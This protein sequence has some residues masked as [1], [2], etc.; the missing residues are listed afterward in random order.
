VLNVCLGKVRAAAEINISPVLSIHPSLMA[1]KW[2]H[3][4]FKNWRMRWQKSTTI[5]GTG[6]EI[7][8]PHHD[9]APSLSHKTHFTLTRLFVFD[10]GVPGRASAWILQRYIKAGHGESAHESSQQRFFSLFYFHHDGVD[11]H[12]RYKYN[13]RLFEY[14]TNL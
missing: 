13:S 10:R 11:I 2:C 7:D 5:D 4:R 3:K 9:K 8:A 6:G 14:T 12:I 1:G